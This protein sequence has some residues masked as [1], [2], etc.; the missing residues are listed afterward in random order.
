MIILS[1]S[2]IIN[3]SKDKTFLCLFDDVTVN[4][5]V[6]KNLMNYFIFIIRCFLCSF[7]YA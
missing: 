5:H 2:F 7:F 1:Q 3:Y 6:K 4:L